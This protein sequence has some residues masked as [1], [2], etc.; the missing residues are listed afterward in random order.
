MS[1]KRPWRAAYGPDRCKA[2]I[3]LKD[4]SSAQCMKVANVPGADSN[5]T[6]CHLHEPTR[7]PGYVSPACE[8]FA[9][10]SNPAR[11]TAEGPKDGGFAPIPICV[12]CA[13]RVGVRITV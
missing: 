4:G 5:F 2:D 8:W 13:E 1:A 3:T 9:A 7:K 11:G 6:Y 12:R 10:C